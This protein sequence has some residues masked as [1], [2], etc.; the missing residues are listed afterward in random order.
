MSAQNSFVVSAAT[1]DGARLF[2]WGIAMVGGGNNTS[3]HHY[4]SE[5]CNTVS[6]VM[7]W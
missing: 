6:C 5:A 4:K 2:Q 3:G 7:T 1:T